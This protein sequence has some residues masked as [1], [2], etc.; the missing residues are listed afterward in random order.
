[1]ILKL[2]IWWILNSSFCWLSDK[3]MSLIPEGT[4]SEMVFF[5]I[6]TELSWVSH[7]KL[8]LKC[9]AMCIVI[10]WLGIRAMRKHYIEPKGTSIG[11][12]RERISKNSSGSVTHANKTSKI[13]SFLRGCSSCFPFPLGFG[14]IAFILGR[15]LEKREMRLRG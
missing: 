1:M 14:Q 6:K 3:E 7:N 8:K 9:C 12:G 13:I 10:Q 5:C 15:N 2:N 4:P 11:K